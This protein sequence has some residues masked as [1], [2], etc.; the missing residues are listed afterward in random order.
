MVASDVKTG[1]KLQLVPSTFLLQ[2][3]L[4]TTP[5]AIVFLTSAILHARKQHVMSSIALAIEG[6]NS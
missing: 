6:F 2:K 4:C 1:I 3:A 5:Y